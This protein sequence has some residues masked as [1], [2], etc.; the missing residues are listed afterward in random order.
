[1]AADD[2]MMRYNVP[3][4][5]DHTQA[6]MSFSQEL[7]QIGQEALHELASIQNF[8][9]TEHGSQGYAQAQQ[10][11]NEGIDDGKQ[12]IARHGDAIDTW[13]SDFLAQDVAAFNSFTGM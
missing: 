12:V 2:G 7:D 5:G 11:I 4:L 13:T 3:Q 6:L 8:F 9:D 10:L 1:M